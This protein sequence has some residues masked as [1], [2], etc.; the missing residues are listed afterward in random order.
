MAISRLT[1]DLNM[2]SVTT[3]NGQLIGVTS[4]GKVWK[5]E[6]HKGRWVPFQHEWKAGE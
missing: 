5:F 4:D 3:H 1:K 2:V 6:D